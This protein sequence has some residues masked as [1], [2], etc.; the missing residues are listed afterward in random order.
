[1]AGLLLVCVAAVLWGTVGVANRLMVAGE[2]VDP[3]LSGLVLR[4]RLSGPETLGCA[5]MVAA[6]VVLFRAERRRT[7]A[8]GGVAPAQP[9]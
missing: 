6:M 8:G 4:E 7:G 9:V 5:L 2:A 3:T 1:M